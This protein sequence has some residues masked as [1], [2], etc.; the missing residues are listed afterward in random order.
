MK[1]TFTFLWLMLLAICSWAQRE[2][3]S[4]IV[5]AETSEPLPYVSIYVSENHGTLTNAD[6]NFTISTDANDSLKVTFI[7]YEPMMLR[8][9]ELPL[10]IEMRALTN[11][12]HEVTVMPIL[13]IIKKVSQN[14]NKEYRRERKRRGKY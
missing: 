14:I 1:R 3:H 13:D 4:K 10:R 7:G 9:G 12:L 11:V 6:G 8:A 5:D 2:F